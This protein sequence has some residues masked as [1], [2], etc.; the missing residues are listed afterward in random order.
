MSMM[1]YGNT[2][3]DARESN[4]IGGL[5]IISY[6]NRLGALARIPRGLHFQ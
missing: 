5:Q 3:C 1:V 2:G 6:A 4:A